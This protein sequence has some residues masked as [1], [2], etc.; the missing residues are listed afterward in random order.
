MT[1]KQWLKHLR[2][3]LLVC[4]IFGGDGVHTY[5]G[6][7]GSGHYACLTCGKVDEDTDDDCEE[8]AG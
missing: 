5:V 2:Y 8:E 7:A 4:P 6:A 3:W 1:F